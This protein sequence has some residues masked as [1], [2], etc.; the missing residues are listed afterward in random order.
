M[1]ESSYNQAKDELK[2]NGIK[3]FKKFIL[4]FIGF[5]FWLVVIL[6]HC[7]FLDIDIYWFASILFYISCFL[8]ILSILIK[9]CILFT[10]GLCIYCFYSLL[11]IVSQIIFICLVLDPIK[12]DE[13]ENYLLYKDKEEFYW[14]TVGFKVFYTIAGIIGI[15]IKILFNIFLVTRIKCFTGYRNYKISISQNTKKDSL[16]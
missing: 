5:V 8:I 7:F 12:S 3:W 11:L 1:Q 13:E 16:I 10:I 2:Y 15:I 14:E 4:V 6:I 9:N